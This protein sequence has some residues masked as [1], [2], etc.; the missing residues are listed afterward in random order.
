M[1]M[2][3]E[4]MAG[5]TTLATVLGGGGGAVWFAKRAWDRIEKSLGDLNGTV[6]GHTV[7]IGILKTEM[8]NAKEDIRDLKDS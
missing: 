8:V 4:L 1:H 7:S 6:K 3:P 2:T 5:L